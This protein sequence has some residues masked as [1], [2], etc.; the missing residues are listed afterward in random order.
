M[1]CGKKEAGGGASASGTATASGAASAKTAATAQ[2]SADA[3]AE[4]PRV[5]HVMRASD[6]CKTPPPGGRGKS[7]VGLKDVTWP[8]GSTLQIHF[9]DGTPELIELVA[10]EASVWQQWANLNFAW[11]KDPKSPPPQVD[12]RISFTCNGEKGFYTRGIGVWSKELADKGEH[13]ICFEALAEHLADP[14]A[15]KHG[16]AAIQH[17][18][19]HLLGLKH[20]QQNPK[21]TKNLHWDVEYVHEWCKKT[22]DWDE[23]HCDSQIL[24]PVTQ[25]I[26]GNWLVSDFDPKSI[27]LYDIPANFTKERIAFPSSDEISETD[28]KGI[29][30]MYPGREPGTA[31]TPGEPGEPGTPTPPTTSTSSPWNETPDA[32]GDGL[33]LDAASEKLGVAEGQAVYRG[34]L[35]VAGPD[36]DKIKSVTYYLPPQIGGAD[37]VPGNANAAGHAIAGLFAIPAEYDS[38]KATVVVELADGRQFK[39]EKTVPLGA[40]TSASGPAARAMG[41]VEV[42]TAG[43][44][45]LTGDE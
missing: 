28:K 10:K 4:K 14:K 7:L 5:P 39:L 23:K 33:V 21:L 42:P 38:Y 26:K 3:V 17:E 22:Q 31:P 30:M 35:A 2:G 18:F 13:T 6:V 9:Q 25:Q 15:H 32:Q 27:M 24:T 41:A 19:G 29:A 20:E 8:N 43:S 44:G 40:V 45:E 36:A 37:A 11:H 12:V 16:I 1:A 34:A